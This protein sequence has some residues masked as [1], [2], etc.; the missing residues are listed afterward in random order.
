MNLAVIKHWGKQEKDD[1]FRLVLVWQTAQISTLT[2]VNASSTDGTELCCSKS[3]NSMK[4]QVPWEPPNCMLECF[5]AGFPTG[6]LSRNWLNIRNC[7]ASLKS[8]AHHTG[9]SI[10]RPLTALWEG[11]RK[12]TNQECCFPKTTQNNELWFLLTVVFPALH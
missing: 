12:E 11:M 2:A 7:S 3:L 8:Q 1:L 10:P 4:K 6:S 5:I 9:F